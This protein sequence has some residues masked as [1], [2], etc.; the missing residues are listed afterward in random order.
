MCTQPPE[1]CDEL[2]S[3][4]TLPSFKFLDKPPLAVEYNTESEEYTIEPVKCNRSS[5]L[6]KNQSDIQ[7]APITI[8]CAT[9]N[10]NPNA[11]TPLPVLTL[12]TSSY[13]QYIHATM[14][15]LEGG[16]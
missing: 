14:F 8:N 16:K 4:N 3:G 10:Y 13:Q 5:N 11:V 9:V 7:A 1:N 12:N 15:C 2:E 6:N